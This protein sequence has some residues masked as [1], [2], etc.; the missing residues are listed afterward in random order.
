MGFYALKILRRIILSLSDDFGPKPLIP[1]LRPVWD[2][3]F[4]L[5]EPAIRVATGLFVM[6][7]GAQKLFGWFGGAGLEATQ[8]VFATKMG[9]PPEMAILAGLTEFI[10]GLGLALGLLTRLSA[11]MVA[12]AMAVAVG[13]IYFQ[14]GK[15]FFGQTGGFEYP[16]LLCILAL[17]F[18]IR[19]GGHCSLD[20]LL[21]REI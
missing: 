9:L 15:G 17:A 3:F 10:G 5:T 14:F 2:A 13:V 16:L 20:R 18:V 6:P 19:G 7:H 4:P 8:Q 12:G 1:A 11:A 21:G